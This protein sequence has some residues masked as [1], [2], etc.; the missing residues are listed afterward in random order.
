MPTLNIMML[1]LQKQAWHWVYYA[2]AQEGLKVINH[3]KTNDDANSPFQF[4]VGRQKRGVFEVMIKRGDAYH[5]WQQIGAVSED[6][7]FYYFIV[8]WLKP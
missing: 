8:L 2:F 3:A 1:L 5:Q 7:I 4:Y 6:G